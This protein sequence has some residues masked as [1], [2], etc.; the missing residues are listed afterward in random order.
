MSQFSHDSEFQKL[1]AHRRDVDLVDAALELAR[2]ADPDLDFRPTQDWIRQRAVE[3]GR[4]AA[5]CR[6]DDAVLGCLISHLAEEHR[7]QGDVAGFDQAECSYLPH[8]IATGRGIPISLSVVYIEIGRRAGIELQ[9]IPAPL[10]FL[11]CYQ[12]EQGPVF[13]DAYAAGRMLSWSECIH[14]LQAHTGLSADQVVATL[15]P[16]SPRLIMTR[17]L[18]NLKGIHCRRQSWELAL[19]VQQRLVAL[20]PADYGAQ[21]DLGRLALQRNVPGLAYEAFKNCVGHSLQKNPQQL[22]QLLR[23]AEQRIAT[24]N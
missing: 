17:M 7:L 24:R 13:I 12:T 2:D 1:L 20:N 3:V 8:V 22:Q 14:W 18:N 5:G 23:E 6:S 16:A 19:R 9:G 4:K 11:S 10:H 15:R 21:F